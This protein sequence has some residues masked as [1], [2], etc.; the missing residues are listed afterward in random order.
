ATVTSALTNPYLSPQILCSTAVSRINNQGIPSSDDAAA[1]L[2][3]TCYFEH[4]VRM[5]LSLSTDMHSLRL[6]LNTFDAHLSNNAFFK[7]TMYQ[8]HFATQ[9]FRRIGEP[10]A[11]EKLEPLLRF[12]SDKGIDVDK[13]I[14]E[15]NVFDSN[16][17]MDAGWG[18]A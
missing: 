10:H 2:P 13:V 6:S 14:R 9:R 11:N 15:F 7:S 3:N 8:Q 16:V 4:H 17:D 18:Y 1:S 12:L 5:N